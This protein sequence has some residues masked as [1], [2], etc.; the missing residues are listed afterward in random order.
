MIIGTVKAG[1][2][3]FLTQ[4]VDADDFIRMVNESIITVFN[5]PDDYFDAIN[6]TKTYLPKPS[7]RQL[8][9]DMSVASHS[10]GLSKVEQAFRLA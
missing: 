3:E 5:I 4:G 6:Q 8:L 9:E 10:F 1:D 2:K 7:E